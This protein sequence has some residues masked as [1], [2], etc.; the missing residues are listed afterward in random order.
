M[1]E[2]P[3]TRGL[4]A[5]N[6]AD[7]GRLAPVL[8]DLSGSAAWAQ[9][10]IDARPFPT[11]EALHSAARD[12]LSGQDDDEVVAA[13]DAHPPIGARGRVS[14][15]SARE[16]SAAASA[17]AEI[18]RRLAEGQTR[19]AD[20]FGRGFLVCATGL[21]AEQVLAEVDRRMAM[22][23]E[24]DLAATREHLTRINALRLDRLLEEGT[25]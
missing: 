10:M 24:Q 6:A 23:P 13:V 7:A 25:L 20:H 5:L 3:R 16:Q 8:T 11:V 4:E 2:N 12:I 15:A 17:D 14:E 19:Y 9:A 18:A 1:T 21:T 22:T